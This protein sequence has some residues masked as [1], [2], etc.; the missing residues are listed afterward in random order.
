MIL[1]SNLTYHGNPVNPV[2]KFSKF[3]FIIGPCMS[4]EIFLENDGNPLVVHDIFGAANLN[5]KTTVFNHG[6]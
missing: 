4:L 5:F 3:I 6:L 2:R 1:I